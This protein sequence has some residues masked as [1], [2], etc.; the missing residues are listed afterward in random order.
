MYICGMDLS[1]TRET[2]AA[3]A[4]SGVR[5]KR[6]LL[7]AVIALR[8]GQGGTI[9]LC[10]GRPLIK[11]GTQ[12]IM[13]DIY[14]PA[15]WSVIVDQLRSVDG[16]ARCEGDTI[17]LVGWRTTRVAPT[18]E[19]D[20][21]VHVKASHLRHWN[22][23]DAKFI[24]ACCSL[25]ERI[26]FK[27]PNT[28]RKHLS[29]SLIEREY[30]NLYGQR[31]SA[32]T[33]VRKKRELPIEWHKVPL[34]VTEEA[35]H[36]L[37]LDSSLV[38]RTIWWADAVDSPF[39]CVRGLLPRDADLL[40]D[41]SVVTAKEGWASYAHIQVSD[42]LHLN[43]YDL[44]RERFRTVYERLTFGD[45]C[46]YGTVTYM[47]TWRKGRRAIVFDQCLTA[48]RRPDGLRRLYGDVAAI[49]RRE[50]IEVAGP[51][52]IMDIVKCIAVESTT[53]ARTVW[54]GSVCR[55]NPAPLLQKYRHYGLAAVCEIDLD[56]NQIV[57]AISMREVA[58]EML[59]CGVRVGLGHRQPSSAPLSSSFTIDRRGYIKSADGMSWLDITRQLY[60]RYEVSRVYPDR[61]HEVSP[62]MA[63]CSR[64]FPDPLLLY[65]GGDGYDVG[66]S[67]A[68]SGQ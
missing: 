11:G 3:I 45:R 58:H 20:I 22:I 1:L 15:N 57:E 56:G 50:G 43:S 38:G 48:T 59:H 30:M 23:G 29:L 2:V 17:R 10:G 51:A 64:T 41:G 53:H 55:R 33:L 9:R 8:H 39:R 7:C 66:T 28:G 61:L 60:D 37:H 26:N 19:V 25:L 54:Y 42:T 32:S 63:Q 24:A 40:P 67:L 52:T 44:R 5:Q 49:L 18:N 68:S 6:R 13:Q 36:M 21:K 65:G 46:A 14:G 34:H 4:R 27:D 35:A 62:L 12:R 31:P 47:R 16:L